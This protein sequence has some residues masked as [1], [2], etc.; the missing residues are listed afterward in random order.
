MNSGDPTLEFAAG[1]LDYH[2]R[3][4]KPVWWAFFDR[5]EL[6]DDE[7]VEDPESIGLLEPTGPSKPDKQSLRH[8]FTYPAQEH[9]LGLGQRPFDPATGKG[10]GEIVEFDRETRV[11]ALKRG[12]ILAST[13]VPT[14]LLPGEPYKTKAQEDA[15]K[16]I[17]RS[18]VGRV[19]EGIAA[20]GSLGSRRDSL[21]SPGSSH[22]PLRAWGPIASGR[23]GRALV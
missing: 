10:A 1:L 21:P 15:I 5:I 17:A 23:I 18:L 16:R 3:E 12:P 19:A 13:P 7:L 14:A 20:P 11:V 8:R 6:S 22:Q 2:D 4:R 9:K